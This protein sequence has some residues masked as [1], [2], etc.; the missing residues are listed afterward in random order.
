MNDLNNDFQGYEF[1]P[2]AAKDA[3]AQTG[4]EPEA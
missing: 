2:A 4:S 3:K 1:D